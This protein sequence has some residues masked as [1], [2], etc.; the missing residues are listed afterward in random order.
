MTSRYVRERELDELVSDLDAA[1]AHLIDCHD[2]WMFAEV[3]PQIWRTKKYDGG[4]AAATLAQ[5]DA[6]T[7]A[8]IIS[9][10][11]AYLNEL[12]WARL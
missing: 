1:A 9:K 7:I 11:A 2:K 10:A 12:R 6:Y 3:L 5:I 8:G 4:R